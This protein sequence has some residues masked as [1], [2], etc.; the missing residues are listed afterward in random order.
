MN[1]P[2]Q[3]LDRKPVELSRRQLIK[4][5]AAGYIVALGGCVQ[6]QALGRQQLLLVSEAQMTQLSASAWN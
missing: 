2:I 3:F 6:N 5:L 1:S 4:G